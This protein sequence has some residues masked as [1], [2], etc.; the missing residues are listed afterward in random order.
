[1]LKIPSACLIIR[2]AAVLA[3]SGGAAAGEY[4]FKRDGVVALDAKSFNDA[5][6][7]DGLIVYYR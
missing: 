6:R 2:L 5:V 3:A 4:S 1:M 7:H